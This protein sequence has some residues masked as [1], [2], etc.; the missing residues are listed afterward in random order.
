[1]TLE[2]EATTL[3]S[4]DKTKASNSRGQGHVTRGQG[5]GQGLNPS[6]EVQHFLTLTLAITLG[7]VHRGL[8]ICRLN[9]DILIDTA[10][11]LKD[12][13]QKIMF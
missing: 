5:R 7:L 10:E 8:V 3:E 4:K 11:P 2:A 13:G 6:F 9:L 12:C 1:M